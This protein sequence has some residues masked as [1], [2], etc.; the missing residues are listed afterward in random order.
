MAYMEVTCI[1]AIRTW[2]VYSLAEQTLDDVYVYICICT[3]LETH[4][5]DYVIMLC[6]LFAE[7]CS[8]KI[9]GITEKPCFTNIRGLGT[10]SILKMLT[11]SLYSGCIVIRDN[12]IL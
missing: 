11:A 8:L 5:H 4:T 3:E 9:V 7:G 10:E 1:R 6:A 2:A 12:K